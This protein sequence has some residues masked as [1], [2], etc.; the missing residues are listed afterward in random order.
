MWHLLRCNLYSTQRLELLN[1]VCI[2]N[3][4]LKYCSNK[5]LLNIILYGSEDSNCNNKFLKMFERLNDP[6][7]DHS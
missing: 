1:N 6:F 7:F 3:P 4:S 2:L 5:K